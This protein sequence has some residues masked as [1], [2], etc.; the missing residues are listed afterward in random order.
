MVIKTNKIANP[1]SL[2]SLKATSQIR[3]EISLIHLPQH[4]LRLDHLSHKTKYK[5]VATW[6][7]IGPSSLN[8]LPQS[9][10]PALPKRQP[11]L[12]HLRPGTGVPRVQPPPFHLGPEPGP[13]ELRLRSRGI[14]EAGHGEDQSSSGEHGIGAVG[15]VQEDAEASG[16]RESHRGRG[17][18]RH[19]MGRG[20]GPVFPRDWSGEGCDGEA[21][22]GAARERH[23]Q[24]WTV[25]RAPRAGVLQ[26]TGF[27]CGSGWDPR[28]GVFQEA[29]QE[30]LINI[31][32][33]YT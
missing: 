7:R 10:R 33:C 31:L 26:A 32:F 5:N 21:V 27:C 9:F 16:V 20:G 22:G 29:K 13:P 17:V 11:F 3:L 4:F 1:I 25:F 8:P 28:H 2:L 15:R 19:H 24:H 6:H 30:I 18:Q 14:P 12:L 23:H